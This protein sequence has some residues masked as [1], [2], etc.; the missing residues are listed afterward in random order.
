[1]KSICDI[2]FLP[3]FELIMKLCNDD[4]TL[5]VVVVGL[6]ISFLVILIHTILVRRRPSYQSSS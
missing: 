4:E 6:L 2:I 5:F 3:V 1:M